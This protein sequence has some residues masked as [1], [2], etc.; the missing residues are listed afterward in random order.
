MINGSAQ[1]FVEGLHYG[2]ER[3]FLY[4]GKKYFIQGYFENDKPMLELYVF[5]P[6]DS[7][8][9]WRVFSDDN[10]YPV[11]DFENAKIFEGKSFWEIEKDIEWVD[12]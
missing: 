2:D 6:S 9:E 3:F 12:C 1:E 4:N 7:D 5:E 10:N 11:A 8:F